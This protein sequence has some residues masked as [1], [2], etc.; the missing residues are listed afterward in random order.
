M[1]T[2]FLR[3]NSAAVCLSIHPL[4]LV[5]LH[6]LAEG[7][8]WS[9]CNHDKLNVA[10][11]SCSQAK[12]HSPLLRHRSSVVYLSSTESALQHC[13]EVAIKQRFKALSTIFQP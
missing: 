10:K 12:E 5:E 13:T 1:C 8:N 6:L 2:V 7:S 9:S 11:V 4:T 3:P